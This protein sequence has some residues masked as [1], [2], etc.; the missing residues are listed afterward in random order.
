MIFNRMAAHV[1]SRGR[2]YGIPS[3]LLSA[4]RCLR[5]LVVYPQH[6]TLSSLNGYRNYVALQSHDDAF[7]H[8]S[9]R[10]YLMRGLTARQRATCVLTHYNFEETTF[11][12][13]YKRAVYLEGGLEV[14][15][16]RTN[17]LEFRITLMIAPRTVAEGEL[18]V[19]L[20]AGETYLHRLNFNW[21]PSSLFGLIPE[22]LPVIVRNQG[23]HLD[24]DAAMASFEAVFPNNSPSFFCFAAMQGIAHA[25]GMNRIIG[26]R[27]EAQI[28]FEPQRRPHF[29]NAYDHFWEK[30]GGVELPCNG[31]LIALPFYSKS[32]LEIP[33]KRRK[34]AAARRRFWDQISD[35]ARCTVQAKRLP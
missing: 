25:A 27:G 33:A 26:T 30:L 16:Y 19:T 21:A 23:R 22:V 11:T 29:M 15:C 1:L 3:V 4:L 5:V 2:Q 35:S 17:S 6:K 20:F 24:S 8:L 28:S 32:L 9:H 13:Q 34:R 10:F 31:Y 12:T 14:W 18:V 7:R